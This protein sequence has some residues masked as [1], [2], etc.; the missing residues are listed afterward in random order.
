MYRNEMRK[1]LHNIT[2]RHWDSDMRIL[3]AKALSA[4]VVAGTDDDLDTSLNVEVRLTI[5]VR[6]L[7]A[8][9]RMLSSADPGSIHGGLLALRELAS[10]L[11]QS[12]GRKATVSHLITTKLT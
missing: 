8:Q 6:L 7:T 3:G 1:Y 5:D 9:T 11:D 4:L 12:D 10:I 2:L